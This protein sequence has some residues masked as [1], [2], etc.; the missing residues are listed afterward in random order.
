MFASL[1]A[2]IPLEPIDLDSGSEAQTRGR[3]T[4][5]LQN[6]LQIT[7]KV[8]RRPSQ[9]DGDVESEQVVG[10]LTV[11]ME[12][13]QKIASPW[14]NPPADDALSK[15]IAAMPPRPKLIAGP[16]HK[17]RIDIA[18]EAGRMMNRMIED[19]TLE[20]SSNC[21]GMKAKVYVALQRDFD[22]QHR[23]SS[24]SKKLYD[25][26]IFVPAGHQAWR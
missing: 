24:S 11:D 7:L 9:R 8:F 19:P 10:G 14:P 20:D 15:A 13:Q 3:Q 22:C 18:I 5:T 25:L 4:S 26:C 12:P 6:I 1:S 21:F 23:R 17:A 16:G 2:T